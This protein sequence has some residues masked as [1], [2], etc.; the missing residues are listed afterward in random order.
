M[1]TGNEDLGPSAANAGYKEEPEQLAFVERGTIHGAI[2]G[3][4]LGFDRNGQLDSVEGL[5]LQV[6]GGNLEFA[7]STGAGS[8]SASNLQ[9]VTYGS[10]T[11]TLASEVK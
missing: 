2:A 7:G 10:G 9:D 3:G 11:L 8:A 1:I 4:T 5:K 6:A